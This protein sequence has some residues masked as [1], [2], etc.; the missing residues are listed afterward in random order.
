MGGG[1]DAETGCFQL[2]RCNKV[3]PPEEM[4]NRERVRGECRGKGG[5]VVIVT[6]VPCD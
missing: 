3:L 6:S 2:S 4:G 5:A 1:I